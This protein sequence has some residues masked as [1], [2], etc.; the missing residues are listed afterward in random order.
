MQQNNWFDDLNTDSMK[1]VTAEEALKMIAVQPQIV[2]A[3]SAALAT[4][5]A[6]RGKKGWA[7]PS[8]TQAIR[9]ALAEVLQAQTA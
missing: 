7:G 8:R 9:D 6:N 2:K 5:D 3:V 1:Q 4:N